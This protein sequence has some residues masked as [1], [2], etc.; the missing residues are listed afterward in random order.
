MP[1]QADLN[2]EHDQFTFSKALFD[3]ALDIPE[4]IIDPQGHEAPK[5]FNVYRNNVMHSLIEAMQQGFPSL[6]NLLGKTRFIA[7]AKAYIRL[8]PPKDPLMM[9]YGD[10][11][12]EFIA[13]YEPLNTIHYL[14]DIAKLDYLKR[15]AYFAKDAYPLEPNWFSAFEM[16]KITAF[17]Y[18]LL[19]AFYV[20][21]S[22]FPIWDIL[23][24][25]QGLKD[26][27]ISPHGQE[28][29]IFRP[30]DEVKLMHAPTGFSA[31][32][33]LITKNH[34][35]E[36]AA[37]MILQKQQDADIPAMIGIVLNNVTAYQEKD[38]LS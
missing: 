12:A 14:S 1:L 9:F 24:R 31:F 8:Y 36:Q 34:T 19:P 33:S 29:L 20:V 7:L 35:I 37:E 30:Y 15:R 22:D 26:H 13:S 16:D 18:T 28:V 3:P 23:Q 5:R 27:S 25:V 11:F 6:E 2:R 10:N 4:N 32:I 17:T 38:N 21:R